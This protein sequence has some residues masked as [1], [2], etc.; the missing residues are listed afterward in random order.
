MITYSYICESGGRTV[1]EDSVSVAEKSGNYCFTLCDGLGGHGNGDVASSAVTEMFAQIFYETNLTPKD[2]F[3]LAYT[4]S[5]EKVL[6]LQK[7]KGTP[8]GMKSTVVSLLLSGNRCYWSHIGD[9]R[10]YCFVKNKVVTRTLDHSVPQMLVLTNELK[11]RQIRFHPDRN[12][13]LRAIGT[14]DEK[15]GFQI[16]QS[17]RIKNCQAFLLCSDG[18]WELITE[19]QMC[20]DLR[21]SLT[22]QEWLERMQKR[23]L[24]KGKNKKMD[25]FSAIAVF[26]NG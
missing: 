2:F 11:E 18:F 24:K 19:R 4:K 15:P 14:D 21:K 8:F 6:E 16:S 12:K 22:P 25:N 26:V 9:S 23:V 1:N 20:R 13:I 7:E 17:L 3:T 10:V 5:N